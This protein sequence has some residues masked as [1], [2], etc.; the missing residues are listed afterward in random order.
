MITSPI[1]NDH[2]HSR[3]L[4]L[5]SNHLNASAADDI[6]YLPAP[7]IPPFDAIDTP[8]NPGDVASQLVC[9]TSPWLSLT[10]PD[11]IVASISRQVL[12]MEISYAAFCGIQNLIIPGPRVSNSSAAAANGVTRFARTVQEV[13]AVAGFVQ[14]AVALPMYSEGQ[15]PHFRPLVGDLEPFC[16]PE[17]KGQEGEGETDRKSV[18]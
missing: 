6:S 7:I 14:I 18:V 13:M 8:L 17:F 12:T 2:F 1:T 11:P 16:R 9:H 4:T 3:V 10:S 5:L 15:E